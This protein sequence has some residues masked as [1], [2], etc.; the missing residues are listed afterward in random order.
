MKAPYNLPLV[1][2]QP[3]PQ[4][5]YL[6]DSWSY[7]IYLKDVDE[8]I[9]HV[10]IHFLHTGTYQCL[11]PEE[12]STPEKQTI[13]F[14][15]S[16]WVYVAARTYKIAE[17]EKLASREAEILSH[18]LDFSSI[19]NELETACPR[20]SADGKW[21]S[22]YLQVQITGLLSRSRP[23]CVGDQ[24]GRSTTSIAQICVQS[25][26]KFSQDKLNPYDSHEISVESEKANETQ[27]MD[28]TEPFPSPSEHPVAD[29]V[30]YSSED[31]AVSE[32]DASLST[33]SS[34]MEAAEDPVAEPPSIQEDDHA[35]P[36]PAEAEAEPSLSTVSPIREVELLWP[37]E[38]PVSMPVDYFLGN[39]S[40]I[41]TDEGLQAEESLP[42]EP[43]VSAN[44]I[45]QELEPV[46]YQEVPD[47]KFMMNYS[48][49]NLEEEEVNHD[50]TSSIQLSPGHEKRETKL[51]RLRN[52][53]SKK[54]GRKSSDDSTMRDSQEL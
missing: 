18:K 42:V 44:E 39:P 52:K 40:I 7:K 26:V 20:P 8:G 3:Y 33:L 2:I 9:G 31:R 34:A 41:E 4:L 11:Q 37:E 21:I 22:E 10:I 15:T 38:T 28:S 1:M 12:R 27:A 23:Y 29:I 54:K 13:E 53:K 5:L 50:P 32:A 43:V 19:L 36:E 47:T 17:L 16:I 49:G 45:V 25:A 14:R 35:C 30:E 51:Q 46:A 6:L 24:G 48:D